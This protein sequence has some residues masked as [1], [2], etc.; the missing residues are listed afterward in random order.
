MAG[1][2]VWHRKAVT[3][4]AGDSDS[5]ARMLGLE[6]SSLA[7]VQPWATHSA[8]LPHGAYCNH[9]YFTQRSFTRIKSGDNIEQFKRARKAPEVRV[10]SSTSALN[11]P[12]APLPVLE[13]P[14]TYPVPCPPFL[15]SLQTH[16]SKPCI[17]REKMI[18]S[19]A[20]LTRDLKIVNEAST[21]T[22]YML[23]GLR[24]G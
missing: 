5:G 22:L 16:A 14:G 24:E 1:T 19:T 21:I 23:R 15:F 17:I 13:D 3:T 9:L 6:M 10:S 12:R 8:C 20:A 4:V 7:T 11:W 2:R 18:S